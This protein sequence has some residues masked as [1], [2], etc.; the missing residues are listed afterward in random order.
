MPYIFVR[1]ILALLELVV[2]QS[3]T[4][5]V[6]KHKC[7]EDNRTR[8]QEAW[9]LLKYSA[10]HATFAKHLTCAKRIFKFYLD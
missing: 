8:G 10:A 5:Y 9:A 7:H 6:I 4:K 2:N 1:K 3:D